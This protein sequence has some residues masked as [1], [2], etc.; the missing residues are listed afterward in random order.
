MDPE[1]RQQFDAAIAD[2]RAG[3]IERAMPVYKRLAEAFPSDGDVLHMNAIAKLQSGDAPGALDHAQRAVAADGSVAKYH[4]TLGVVLLTLERFAEAAKAF[5]WAIALAPD[6]S[7]ARFNLGNALASLG[8]IDAAVTAYKALIERDDAHID[9]LNNL[10]GLLAKTGRRAEALPYLE[11]AHRLAPE[12]GDILANLVDCLERLNRLEDAAEKAIALDARAPDTPIAQ[13]LVARIERRTERLAEAAARLEKIVA[14]NADPR[15]TMR[16]HFDLGQVLERSGDDER[17]FDAFAA[18]NMLQASLF[19]QFSPDD[20]PFLKRTRQSRAWYAG[21]ALSIAPSQS[22]GAP[23]PIFM[24]G[25]PRSGTTLLERMLGAHPNLLTTGERSPIEAIERRLAESGDYPACLTAMSENQKADLRAEIRQF[26]ADNAT[27]PP[28]Q[29]RIVDKLPLNIT[30]LG[31]IWTLFPDAP[32][33]VSLRDPRDACLSCFMQ[34]FQMN[35][36]MAHFSSLATTARLYDA[37]MGLWLEYRK[38]AQGRW[39]EVRYE[40]LIADFESHIGAILEFLDIPWDDSVKSYRDRAIDDDISTPSYVAVS[41]QLNTRAQGR[42][43]R[44][45]GQLAPYQ[46]QL[47]PYVE[48]FGYE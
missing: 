46:A 47:A 21:H 11:T 2:H 7:D 48:A 37:V 42:W 16:A 23:P 3:R 40:N 6:L 14:A 34:Q 33:V 8:N 28:G 29:R 24:V 1:S 25:F 13:I 41:E 5:E 9:A 31:L 27:T 45:E 32:V 30:A 43:K 19:R 12:N 39:M 17:A 18:G 38:H 20:S 44:Y 36:A 10:G 35:D 4:N 26:F 15:M 22:D